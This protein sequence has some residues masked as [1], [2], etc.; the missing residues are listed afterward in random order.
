MNI[1]VLIKQ[2]P[3]VSDIQI[4]SQNHNLVRVGAPTMLNPVDKNAIEAALAI[5]ETLGGTVTL[6]SMGTAMASEALREGVS[7]GADGGVLLSDERM[8]GS[9]TLA[10]GKIL[11]LAIKKLAP[12]DLVL[13]GKQSADGDTGQ[14]PPAIAEH[15]GFNLVTYAESLTAEDGV[16]RATRKNRGGME[17][18]EAALPAVCSVMESM[19]VPR[20]PS[21]RN[22]MKAK[23]AVFDVWRLEDI[24][25]DPAES[26][27]AGSATDVTELFAPE[28]HAVGIMIDGNTAE[29]AVLKLMA[30]MKAK[31]LI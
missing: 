9:D 14:I 26:G 31:K 1:V 22:K 27:S 6:V 2:V 10:T 29:E 24:G 25:L 13:T 16:V 21:I 17:T 7:M 8:A 23:K 18:V 15:L 20:S 5:K 12:V 19:N 11:A 3:A 30:D 4:D 28:K